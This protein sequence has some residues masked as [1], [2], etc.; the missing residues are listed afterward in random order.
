MHRRIK[1]GIYTQELPKLETTVLLGLEKSTE[2]AINI[3]KTSAK[4]E[5]MKTS[6]G[7]AQWRGS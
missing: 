7:R 6:G 5:P 4:I 3:R 2:A 1:L